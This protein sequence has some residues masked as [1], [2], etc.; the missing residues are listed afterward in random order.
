MVDP[1]QISKSIELLL[2]LYHFSPRGEKKRLPEWGERMRRRLTYRYVPVYQHIV[3]TGT[4]LIPGAIDPA[5]EEGRMERRW[6]RQRRSLAEA[7]R[8]RSPQMRGPH[9]FRNNMAVGFAQQ[10]AV[11]GAAVSMALAHELSSTGLHV[12]DNAVGDRH[13]RSATMKRTKIEAFMM[14]LEKLQASM[15]DGGLE[16]KAKGRRTLFIGHNGWERVAVEGVKPVA[17]LWAP[18]RWTL[19]IVKKR[20]CGHVYNEQEY[21]KDEGIYQKVQE[22]RITTDQKQRK[23]NDGSFVP[24]PYPHLRRRLC[25]EGGR[26]RRSPAAS[27]SMSMKDEEAPRRTRLPPVGGEWELDAE[28]AGAMSADPRR[29]VPC[30][31]QCSARAA[32]GASRRTARKFRRRTRLPLGRTASE[33]AAADGDG[34]LFPSPNLATKHTNT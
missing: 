32:S 1:P 21:K 26:H 15:A 22:G 9:I 33:E 4:G 16:S 20:F 19:P 17:I 24:P 5:A 14:K 11:G 10:A 12:T 7:C 6:R 3:G 25:L 30:P 8:L 18:Y 2:R 23:A 29:R 31:C 34:R 13:R 27:S 28:R